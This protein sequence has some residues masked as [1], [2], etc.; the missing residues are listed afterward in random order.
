MSLKYEPSPG[1]PCA[2]ELGDRPA[3]GGKIKAEIEEGEAAG[4]I[5]E[6]H[7]RRCP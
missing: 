5:F 2:F 1:Q 4:A 7:S 3:R 6:G